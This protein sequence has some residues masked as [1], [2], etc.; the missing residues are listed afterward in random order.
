M[1]KDL[2]NLNVN[3]CKMCM[4]MGSVTA[5]YGLAGCMT[6]LHG[7]QGCSTYIRR[8]LA[9]HFNEPIDIA[10]SSLT[11]EGTVFGGEKNLVKGLD[12]LIRL[13]DPAVIGVSTTCL[14]ETIGEDIPGIIR[15]YRQNRPGLKAKIVTVSSAGYAGTQYEGFFR[16]LR[17]LV[18]QV[19]P[20]TERHG[21]INVVTGPVSPAD[22]RWLRE[23]LA[24][25]GLD[26]ILLPDPSSNLDGGATKKYERLPRG[27]V[28]LGDIARMA[29]AAH[30]IELAEFVPEEASPALYLNRRH[31]V[32]FTRLPLP[33]GLRDMDRLAE[34]L[35]SLGGRRPPRLEEARS[36]RLDAMVDSHK[37]SA[38]VRAAVFGEPDFVY[39]VSRLL[40]ENGALPVLAATGSRLP[41]FADRVRPDIE[42]AAAYRMEEDFSLLDDC[43]FETIESEAVRLGANVLVGSSDARR[44]AERRRLPLVRAAFPVHDRVGGQRI[45]TLGYEGGL[46]LLDRI[47]NAVLGSVEAS[48]RE[49]LKEKYYLERESRPAAEPPG[50][51]EAALAANRLRSGRHPC[52]NGGGYARI[53]LPVAPNCNIQCNYC[54]RDFSCPNES[55]PGVTAR[56]VTPGE[57]AARFVAFRDASENLSVAGIAGPGD[58]LADWELTRETLR[59][60][61]AADPDVILCLST[62]GLL[63][64]RHV[65]EMAALG[66]SHLTVTVNAVDPAVGAAICRQVDYLGTRYHGEAGAAILMANQFAGIAMAIESGIVCKMNTVMLKGVNDGHIPLIAAKARELGCVLGNIMRMAP[67]KGSVFADSPPVSNREIG[68][69][70]KRCGVHLRQMAHCRQ[71][72]ADAA[73]RLD[74]DRSILF[75]GGGDE[76]AGERQP[77]FF[78]FAV[79]SKGGV[80]KEKR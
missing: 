56:V 76:P 51:G 43:D 52:F 1:S 32:P 19:E 20:E 68:A 37:Y 59:L 27:G 3:P 33:V 29:G 42:K 67:A 54:V 70:R 28:A 41:G 26:C 38:G 69:M 47:V 65:R 2:V 39:A 66:V 25:T 40:C 64:P 77:G 63:L 11:E 46:D 30:T 23:C 57:A 14:A 58:A 31:G 4:P 44:I 62:N 24:E 34:L 74:E 79:S 10:S 45:R 17:A 22:A 73:G 12:N 48:F 71:C 60:I 5:F 6:I 50:A 35:A 21:G 18:E 78:R 75:A 9:T 15:S 55:R 36:R 7:S 49:E 16:A 72:R 8:H 80:L 13:Y 53:H 61:R